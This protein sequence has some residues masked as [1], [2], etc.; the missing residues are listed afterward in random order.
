MIFENF[1]SWE[2]FYFLS[3]LL[4]ALPNFH[5]QSFFS[6]CVFFGIST[7]LLGQSFFFLSFIIYY[8]NVLP[9]SPVTCILVSPPTHPLPR[10]LSIYLDVWSFWRLFL[11]SFYLSCFTAEIPS[12]VHGEMRNLWVV[13]ALLCFKLFFAIR[14]EM[15]I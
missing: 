11:S 7:S 14:V 12:R 8:A 9:L 15:R 10:I 4:L 1:I 2:A 13:C 5:M 3:F 6:A